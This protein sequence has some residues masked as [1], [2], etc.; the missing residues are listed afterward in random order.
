MVLNIAMKSIHFEW[1]YIY[2]KLIH[3]LNRDNIF[4][5]NKDDT[6]T[7]HISIPFNFSFLFDCLARM[8][9]SE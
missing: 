8:P 1:I 9:S 2:F 4:P 5:S 7:L 6:Q 3:I